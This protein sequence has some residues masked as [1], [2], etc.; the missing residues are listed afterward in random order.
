MKFKCVSNWASDADVY[1]IVKNVWNFHGKYDLTAGDDYDTLIIFDGNM[2]GSTGLN[3]AIITSPK[4]NTFAF[5]H[6]P[7]WNPSWSPRLSEACNTIFYG[8]KL[9]DNINTDYPSCLVPHVFKTMHVNGIYINDHKTKNLSI[10]VSN[11]NHVPR[12]NFIKKLLASDIDFDMFGSGWGSVPDHRYK[13]EIENKVGGLESYK[14]SICIESM[15]EDNYISE[16]FTDAI[17]TNTI[18]IY[19][20]ARNIGRF[21]PKCYEELDILSDHC[22]DDLKAILNLPYSF[23]QEMFDAAKQLYFEEYNPLSIVTKISNF[24][25]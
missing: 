17:L 14:Y 5:I 4:E 8:K 2:I 3:T 10:V 23:D 1:S 7:N 6:E 24:P 19:W 16:K 20:G 18:P 21:Y 25:L 15:S 22:I 9:L 13:G 11:K 12:L